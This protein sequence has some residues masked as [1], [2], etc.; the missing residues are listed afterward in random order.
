M[1]SMPEEQPF[2]EAST[3]FF[4]GSSPPSYSTA[5]PPPAAEPASPAAG[6][7]DYGGGYASGGSLSP[8]A[9]QDSFS[10][11][12]GRTGASGGRP[13]GTAGMHTH[14]GA[15]AG[16]AQHGSLPVWPGNLICLLA[17]LSPISPWLT[18]AP[19]AADSMWASRPLRADSSL[20]QRPAS[21]SYYPE[22]PP[23]A[24]SP[25]GA[26]GGGAWRQG[27]GVPGS[28]GPRWVR[29]P[30]VWQPCVMVGGPVQLQAK[31]SGRL[32]VASACCRQ[33]PSC[34]Q[35]TLVP[36]AAPHAAPRMRAA[37]AARSAR[38]AAAA[39]AASIPTTQ[40]GAGLA[41]CSRWLC[42][43]P[44]AVAPAQFRSALHGAQVQAP[45]YL[46]DAPLAPICPTPAPHV[47]APCP[48]RPAASTAPSA[49]SWQA[50]AA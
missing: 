43:L 42:P 22:E 14:E 37:T 18:R 20:A 9:R 2:G 27:S 29:Q 7:A 5:P 6:G 15:A 36:P 48:T 28:S 32:G 10:A 23:A 31:E 13:A 50:S 17:V 45:C 33:P 35:I 21:D 11:A 30:W 4:G 39:R 44:S 41:E 12:T 1:P 16:C 40:V 19:F 34:M 25:T 24:A 38:R 3:S 8:V 47:Q 49:A 46:I 26:S